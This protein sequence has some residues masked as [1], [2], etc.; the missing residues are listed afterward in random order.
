[1][2]TYLTIKL[3]QGDLTAHWEAA[4]LHADLSAHLGS[5]VEECVAATPESTVLLGWSKLGGI[6]GESNKRQ[7]NVAPPQRPRDFQTDNTGMGCKDEQLW[8][9]GAKDIKNKNPTTVGFHLPLSCC[10]EVVKNK[11][12]HVSDSWINN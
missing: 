7:R 12:D 1:M 4:G 3:P 10:V 5:D 8:Q 9:A 11:L 2:I 6:V